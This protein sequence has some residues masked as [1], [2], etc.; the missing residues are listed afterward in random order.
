MT[1]FT[2]TNGD[3]I[4][5]PA[6]SDNSGDDDFFGLDGNDIIHAGLG[7]D[8]LDAGSGDDRLYGEDGDDFVSGGA[9]NDRLYGGNG[10]DWLDGGGGNDILDGGVGADTMVGN[11]GNDIYYVDDV[12]D[13]T[14]E[15]SAGD[16]LDTVYS[17]V[18]FTL[19]SSSTI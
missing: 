6:G 17:S 1:T 5:P 2:G 12:G 18:S 4:L 13:V 19:A 16:G 3:D 14:T 15:F 11:F 8:N 7:N 10:V 9:D